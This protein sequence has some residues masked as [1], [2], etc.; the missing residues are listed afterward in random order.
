MNKQPIVGW[1]YF[2]DIYCAEC[3]NDL[4]DIDPENNEK[5]P[6]FS[7]DVRNLVDTWNGEVSYKTCGACDKSANK[8]K[9][10]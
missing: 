8:W 3:G 6:I 10:L 7:W 1:S 5:H 9:S 2:A 4:P